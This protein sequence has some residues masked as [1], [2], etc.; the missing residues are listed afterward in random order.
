VDT[1]VERDLAVVRRLDLRL[2]YVLETHA[3]ADHITG[4]GK[5]RE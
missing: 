3:H 2:H 4:A 5:L 1:Q